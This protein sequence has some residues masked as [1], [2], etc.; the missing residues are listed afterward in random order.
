M[1]RTLEFHNILSISSGITAVPTAPNYKM[2]S[3]FIDI[4]VR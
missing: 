1:D 4:A 2:P 3:Q